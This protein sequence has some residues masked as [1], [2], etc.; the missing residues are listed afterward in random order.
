MVSIPGVDYAWS[1]PGGA[2]IRAAGR[3][4]ACRYLGQDG[5]KILT[6]AEADDLATHDVWSVVVY[7][8]AADR[9]LGGR[10]VGIGDAQRGLA[11]ALAA[12]MPAGRPIFFAVDFD[13]TAAQQS[14]IN[15]YLDGA[16]SVIGLD[17]VGIYGGYWPV[18]RALDGGHA[19]WAWQTV[20]WS[21][22]SRDPRMVILQPATTVKIND[23]T[24][25]NDTATA[26]DYGQW[27][28]GILPEAA[29]AAVDLTPA[30][31]TQVV[32][33]VWNHLADS[34]TDPGPNPARSMETFLRYGDA[35]YQSTLD[36]I[37]DVK[38]SVLSAVSAIS[39]KTATAVV[40][41][42]TPLIDA[43]VDTQ[44]IIDAVIP[45]LENALANTV[46]HVTVT[47][48]PAVSNVANGG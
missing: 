12:G 36:S 37:G 19:T 47:G 16:A 10:S 43:D 30:A 17:W 35:H 38:T 15:A 42:L 41:A 27:M 3:S 45:A 31:V 18:K 6:A 33:G 4:F 20:A 21:G 13:A 14:A 28:P 48:T 22:A 11:Q 44:A 23:V 2:A 39:G 5:S 7:E 40:Q 34:P 9:A 32:N 8:D 1:H 29:M 24:C 26:D 46:I 25:D